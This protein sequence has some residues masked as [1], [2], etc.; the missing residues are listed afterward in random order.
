MTKTILYGTVLAAIAEILGMKNPASMKPHLHVDA[1]VHLYES[2][3]AILDFYTLWEWFYD[4]W[5]SDDF[6][7]NPFLKLLGSALIRK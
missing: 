5:P 2:D 4:F 1:L 3:D 6:A 7:K